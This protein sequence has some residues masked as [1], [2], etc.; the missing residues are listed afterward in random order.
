MILGMAILLG[1]D[2]GF[3]S[4]QPRMI[5][6]KRAISYDSFVDDSLLPKR[7]LS[8]KKQGKFIEREDTRSDDADEDFTHQQH[9]RNLRG[10]QGK[11]IEEDD[12]VSGDSLDECSLNQY[13]K[14]HRPGSP[15]FGRVKM[16]MLSIGLNYNKRPAAAP[17]ELQHWT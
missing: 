12:I 7:N 17:A 11:Y 2:T 3:R 15:N 1:S 14:I 8:R 9:W 6:E 4:K 13:R 10:K 5:K 16:L